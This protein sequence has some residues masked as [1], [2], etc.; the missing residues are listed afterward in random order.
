MKKKCNVC[1]NQF[2]KLFNLGNHPCADT[3]LKSKKKAI[4]VKKKPL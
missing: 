4:K 1:G 3:F 2:S